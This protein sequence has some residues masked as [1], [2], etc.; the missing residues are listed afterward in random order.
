M[1]IR[2]GDNAIGFTLPARPGETVD[3]GEYLGKDKL[4]LLFFPLAYSPVCTDEM[5]GLRDSWDEWKTLDAKVFGI[6]VDSPF[7][8]DRF[9]AEMDIPFPIL[10]DF[11][12][13]VSAQYGALHDELMGLK[14]VAKRAAFVIDG[15]GTVIYDWVSDDPSKLPDFEAIKAALAG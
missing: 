3:I 8:T 1:S 14:G 13:D 10:S 11:N 15:S 9:R 12:R 2:K 7:V 6:S 4:V 5:C